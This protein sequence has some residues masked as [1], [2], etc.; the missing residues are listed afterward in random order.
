MRKLNTNN[1]LPGMCDPL[2]LDDVKAIHEE[3]KH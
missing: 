2:I 1:M 3:T